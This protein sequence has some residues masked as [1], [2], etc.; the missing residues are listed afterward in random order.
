MVKCWI[1]KHSKLINNK[2]QPKQRMTRSNST[3]INLIF[4]NNYEHFAHCDIHL[5]KIRAHKWDGSSNDWKG[6][7]NAQLTEIIYGWLCVGIM[8]DPF[9]GWRQSIQETIWY[10]GRTMHLLTN[11]VTKY[12]ADF[13]GLICYGFKQF[14]YLKYLASTNYAHKQ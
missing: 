13:V 8:C 5:N 10:A 1:R 4:H 14:I 9:I 7:F 11:N 12:D 6:T 2:M 3:V